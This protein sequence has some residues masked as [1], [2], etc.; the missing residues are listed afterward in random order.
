MRATLRLSSPA[1]L[2]QPKITS[3]TASQSTDG[4][5]RH[6]RAG[7]DGGEVVGA[8]V[9]QGAAVAADRRADGVAD[10]GVG[11]GDPPI[12]ASRWPRTSGVWRQAGGV[13]QLSRMHRR[14]R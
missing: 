11:H 12:I 13:P 1:W 8:D 5:A 6:Q 2:A 14:M 9:V 4:I 3:S 7:A 10:I